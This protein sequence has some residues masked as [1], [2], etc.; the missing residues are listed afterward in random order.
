MLLI[1]V[2]SILSSPT[3]ADNKDH[4]CLEWQ[5]FDKLDQSMTKRINLFVTDDRVLLSHETKL[6]LPCFL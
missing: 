5:V 3:H 1:K 2:M 4:L 6:F